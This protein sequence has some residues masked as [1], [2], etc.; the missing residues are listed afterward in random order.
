MDER[1]WLWIFYIV[2]VA[3]VFIFA[4]I[5]IGKGKIVRD[6][7]FFAKDIALS[8]NEIGSAKGKVTVEYRDIPEIKKLSEGVVKVG[9]TGN[10]WYI[11]GEKKFVKKTEKDKVIIIG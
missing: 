6:D 7:M 9:D 3:F 2:L 8:L 11:A 10:Y 4:Y 1:Q 5:Q